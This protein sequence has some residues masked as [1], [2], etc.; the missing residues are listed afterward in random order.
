MHGIAPIPVESFPDPAAVRSL[1]TSLTSRGGAAPKA[2]PQAVKSPNNC[3]R[4]ERVLLSCVVI[5][6]VLLNAA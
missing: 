1:I 4:S 6:P 2:R 3:R 5:S